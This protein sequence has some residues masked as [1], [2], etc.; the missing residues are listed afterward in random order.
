MSDLRPLCAATQGDAP[1]CCD[2]CV[3]WQHRTQD[4]DADAKARW[5]SQMERGF[6]AWGRIVTENGRF[7]GLVQYGPSAQFPRARTMPAGPPSKDAALLTCAYLAGDDRHGTCERLFLEALADL[8]GRRIS[9]V[10]TFGLRYPEDVGQEE[11]FHAHHT[12][13]DR[14]FL[15]RLGFAPLRSRGQVSLMRLELG[16]LVGAPRRS[17]AARIVQ[18]LRNLQPAL[19]PPVMI[20]AAL[21]QRDR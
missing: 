11:R 19:A 5:A 4:V 18:P 12:L 17:L 7:R 14:A 21:D 1:D 8:K 10:E 16:G 3:F 9:A 15:E 2:A 20:R 6:G 13:F